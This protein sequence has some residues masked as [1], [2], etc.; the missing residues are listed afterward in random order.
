[1]I[2]VSQ[3]VRINPAFPYRD[4]KVLLLAPTAVMAAQPVI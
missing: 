4:I 2:T 3:G 1:M